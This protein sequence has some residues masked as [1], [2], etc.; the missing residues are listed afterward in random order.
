MT[1]IVK[2]SHVSRALINLNKKKHLRAIESRAKG[3]LPSIDLYSTLNLELSLI[4]I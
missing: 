3:D 4:H 1:G 2:F